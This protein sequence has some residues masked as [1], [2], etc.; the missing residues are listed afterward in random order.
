MPHSSFPI[1]LGDLWTLQARSGEGAELTGLEPSHVNPA[2]IYW[3]SW[4]RLE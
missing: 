2:V 1:A 4:R 3:I